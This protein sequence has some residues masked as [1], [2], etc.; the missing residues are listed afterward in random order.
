MI[1]KVHQQKREILTGN[2]SLRS[3]ESR[4]NRPW[5][6]GTLFSTRYKNDIFL[7]KAKGRDSRNVRKKD[8]DPQFWKRDTPTLKFYWN[9]ADNIFNRK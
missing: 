2:E 7:G 9:V 6:E 1:Q 4:R 3:Q 8:G 5:G